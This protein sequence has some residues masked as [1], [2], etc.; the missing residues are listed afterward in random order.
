MS[1]RSAPPGRYPKGHLARACIRHGRPRLS[2]GGRVGREHVRT[3]RTRTSV[4]SPIGS[5]IRARARTRL[6]VRLVSYMRLHP[7]LVAR[8]GRSAVQVANTIARSLA[9]VDFLVGVKIGTRRHGIGVDQKVNVLVPHRW[10]HLELVCI[11]IDVVTA[12]RVPHVVRGREGPPRGQGRQCLRAGH[13]A[14]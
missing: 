12:L 3:C 14:I 7:D 2:R 1:V 4:D 13:V 6:G 10:I 9:G 8:I 5:F 11:A